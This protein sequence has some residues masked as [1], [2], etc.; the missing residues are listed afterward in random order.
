MYL[1]RTSLR[2]SVQ[3]NGTL[4]FAV[5]NTEQVMNRSYTHL[6]V[7]IYPATLREG[8]HLR[9]GYFNDSCIERRAEERNPVRVMSKRNLSIRSR[10]AKVT[11]KKT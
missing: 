4:Y 3:V 11:Q 1:M 9:T 6:K 2:I 8:L 5:D 7:I 10:A